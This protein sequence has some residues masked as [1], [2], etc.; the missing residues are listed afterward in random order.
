MEYFSCE[1][2]RTGFNF[3]RS[4]KI[5]SCCM[6]ISP[7]LEIAHIHDTNITDKIL[8]GQNRLIQK[9]KS[10]NA[11]KCCQN[12]SRFLKD[13]WPDRLE[14]QLYKIQ[15][16]HYRLCNLQCVH[17]GYR[18]NDPSET[19]TPHESILPV[20]QSCIDA[21]ICRPDLFLEVGG[22]E[23]SLA[24]GM[25]NLLEKAIE[26]RWKAIINSN[27]AKFSNIFATG[28]NQDLFTLLL[29]PDAGSPEIYKKIKGADNFHN[30]WRNIGRYMAQTRGK[31]LVKFILE[32]GNITD[33]PAMIKT[34]SQY[35]VKQLVLSMDMGVP[36]REYPL[37]IAKAGEFMKEAARSGLS[38]MRGAFLPPF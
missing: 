32:A 2:I 31:A 34:A 17:C 28:V 5:T 18:R 35:G 6:R 21:G 7:D 27:G 20:L 3:Y 11:P 24:Q 38:V 14:N 26:Y 37:Y 36:E 25:E 15:L 19:D 29:T 4:G 1:N 16:N 23:P 10:G 8:E 22:G 13:N 9:H 30:T 12:C 33:I